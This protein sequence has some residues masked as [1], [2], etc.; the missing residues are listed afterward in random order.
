MPDDNIGLN[1]KKPYLMNKS[2]KSEVPYIVSEKE[3]LLQR[4]FFDHL[5]NLATVDK[6]NVYINDDI[7]G[8]KNGELLDEDFTGTFL[9]IQ[10][11]K[12]V[13]IH[14]TDIIT[15]YKCNLSKKFIFK[16]ILDMDLIKTKNIYK[17][18]VEVN[19]LKGMQEIIN[20]VLFSKFLMKNY[21]TESKDMS[22]NDMALKRNLLF[23][24][25]KLFDWFY[26]GNKVGVYNILDEASINLVKGAIENGKLIN[27]S[28]RFNLRWSLK[29]YFDGGKD[30]G[31][32]IY[33]VRNNLRVKIN[34]SI[35]SKFDSDEEYYYAVG[36][37]VNY[38]L[39][40]SKG[41]KKM[42]SLANPFFNATNSEN[43]NIKLRALFKKY[44]YEIEMN[45]K[46]FNNLYGMIVGYNTEKKVDQDLIL[47]GY[48]QSSLIY[49]SNKNDG[50]EING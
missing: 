38:F 42:H 13:E 14:E 15:G 50:G 18:G 16:N 43:I 39:S 30:M 36:Q 24:R 20:E 32:T 45:S 35:T 2:R 29:K 11:G 3:V 25:E 1:T 47:A 48:L 10:K 37:L 6:F 44:N 28:H 5:M 46:R 12:E 8:Y 19:T 40:R 9:R 49:E 7:K 4:K 21:F 22:I 27:A 31:D 33:D 26:K 23:A 17:Y 41:K 34:E